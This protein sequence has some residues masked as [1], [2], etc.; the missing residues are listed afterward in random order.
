VTS[1][2]RFSPNFQNHPTGINKIFHFFVSGLNRVVLMGS[3]ANLTPSIALQALAAPYTNSGG[4]TGTSVHLFPNLGASASF[5]R[6]MWHRV[7]LVLVANRPGVADGS[8]TLAVNGRSLLRYDG[9]TFSP[10]NGSGVWEGM[11]WS[12]TWGG[13]GGV[14]AELMYMQMDHIIVLGK[15]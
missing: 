9:I 12:P 3:G 11:N 6:G 5:T 1:W 15:Q 14:V 13:S 2:L 4:Q 7:D 8:V 10:A